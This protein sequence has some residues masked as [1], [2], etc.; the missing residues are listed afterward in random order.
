M[1]RLWPRTQQEQ[2]DYHLKRN[3]APEFDVGQP[4]R[5]D[6]ARLFIE[7]IMRKDLRPGIRVEPEPALRFVELGCGAGDVTGPFSQPGWWPYIGGGGYS[8]HNIEV[9]GIDVVPIAAQ[10]IGE[11]YPNMTAIVSPVE[12]LEPMDCDL[13]VMTEFLEH[14]HDPV[15]LTAKWMPH[16]K[17]ALI[18][19]PLNEPNPPYE[20]GHIWSYTK[21]DWAAW[22]L[23][24]GFHIWER[25]LFP[26]GYWEDMV[27]G[28]GSRQS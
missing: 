13:L 27:M 7:K 9:V 24:N 1:E 17:W 2:L 11:R 8:T 14:V 15:A 6:L 5:I 18:G 16:A 10:K 12:E 25:I 23:N 4:G 20:T 19:H 22:F 21:D 28:H 26:M 3:D